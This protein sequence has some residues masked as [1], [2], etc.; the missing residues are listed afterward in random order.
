VGLNVT[1]LSRKKFADIYEETPNAMPTE[2][3]RIMFLLNVHTHLSGYTVPLSI[4]QYAL[5]IWRQCP[6]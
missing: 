6:P 2:K 5:K 3:N 1:R 4:K